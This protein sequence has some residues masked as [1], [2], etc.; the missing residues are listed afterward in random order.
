MWRV[1]GNYPMKTLFTDKFLDEPDTSREKL[2]EE[3]PAW[4]YVFLPK[5]QIYC[6]GT[7]GVC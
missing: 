6:L 7:K 4:E 1:F 2:I 5:G 3:R